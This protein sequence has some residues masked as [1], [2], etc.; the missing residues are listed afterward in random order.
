MV[1]H[2]VN[3]VLLLCSQIPLKSESWHSNL[4][5]LSQL[6]GAR[7]L[8]KRTGSRVLPTYAEVVEVSFKAGP[9]K[10]H[11]WAKVVRWEPGV[12]SVNRTPAVTLWCTCG[13]IKKFFISFLHSVTMPSLLQFLAVN[14]DCLTLNEYV[15]CSLCGTNWIF[16]I[17]KCY[18]I[19]YSEQL[20]CSVLLHRE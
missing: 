13:N 7:E 19:M 5:C 10:L 1:G 6:S 9:P 18:T 3:F 2:R 12:L 17:K 14:T 20:L 4:L 8:Q 15:V 16:T 11:K